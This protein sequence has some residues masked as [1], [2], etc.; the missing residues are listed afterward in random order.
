MGRVHHLMIRSCIKGVLFGWALLAILIYLNVM[1]L[2]ALIF[3]GADRYLATGILMLGFAITFGNAAMGH[4]VM[5]IQRHENRAAKRAANK[6]KAP[7]R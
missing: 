6:R 1:N 2:R 3:T 5:N 4:A 7:N